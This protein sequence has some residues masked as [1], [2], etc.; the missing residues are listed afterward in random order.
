LLE[1]PR[2]CRFNP[3]VLRCRRGVPA[4][5][6]CLTAPQV[7]ALKRIYAGPRTSRGKRI[8]PGYVPGG[9]M[10]SGDDL[11]PAGEPSLSGWEDWIVGEALGY[12]HPIQDSFFKYL[13]FEDPGW[14]WRTFDFDRAPKLTAEKVGA[15]LDAVDADLSALRARGGKIVMYHGWSDPAIPA[16]ASIDYYERVRRTMGRAETGDFFRLFMAPGMQ[17]CAGGPGP[18]TFDAVGA[19]ER[20][21]E[22]GTVPDAIVATHRTDG[23]VDRTRPLCPF[24]QVARYDGSGD[25]DDAASF[26]CAKPRR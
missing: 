19:L 10:G 3:K 12:H 2:R 20:W 1:D 26:S 6:G 11:G 14:D 17:H 16:L 21:V 25:P 22:E 8:F 4:P 9:E 24:P 5:D 18:N 15:V 7:K 23:V 13:V